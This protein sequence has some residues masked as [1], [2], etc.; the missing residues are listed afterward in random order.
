VIIKK[1]L[2]ASRDYMFSHLHRLT[3]ISA[4]KEPAIFYNGRTIIMNTLPR[5]DISL[6][7]ANHRKKFWSMRG[8]L[9]WES[10]I[11]YNTPGNTA[12]ISPKMVVLTALMAATSLGAY[13]VPALAQDVDQ[14]VERNNE[15]SQSITQSNEA[16]TNTVVAVEDDEGDQYVEAYQSNKCYVEQSNEAEQEAEIDD[17]SYNEIFNI[18]LQDFGFYY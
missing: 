13:A 16:C 1:D 11:K 8:E 6:T 10:F 14:D 12:M 3:G 2:K 7:V 4:T 17:E 18:N 15:I 9:S 5:Y